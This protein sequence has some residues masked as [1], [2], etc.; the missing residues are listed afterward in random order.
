MLPII[1]D[2]LW[3]TVKDSS[4][5]RF[6]K[7]QCALE[8]SQLNHALTGSERPRPRSRNGYGG[9]TRY[10]SPFSAKTMDDAWNSSSILTLLLARP[11]WWE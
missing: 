2:L 6:T 9:A 3:T 11:C 5:H 4:K 7:N 8:M 1:T 10:A